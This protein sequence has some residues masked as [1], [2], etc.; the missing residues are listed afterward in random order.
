MNPESRIKLIRSL[1][2]IRL[3]EQH[4]QSTTMKSLNKWGLIVAYFVVAFFA[5]GSELKQNMLMLLFM[6]IPTAAYSIWLSFKNKL[7]ERHK[8][9]ATAVLELGSIAQEE[10]LGVADSIQHEQTTVKSR[11]RSVKR[12]K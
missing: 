3:F 1:E 8:V 4:N 5:Y 11:K 12:K 10:N 6:V 7:D 9:L 2:E